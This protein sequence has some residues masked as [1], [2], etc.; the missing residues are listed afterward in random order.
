[1]PYIRKTADE[2]WLLCNYGHGEGWEHECTELKAKDARERLKEYRENAP[3]YRY[4]VVHK[5]VKIAQK[6]G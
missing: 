1:M 5:R 6:E 4:R 3:E 2:Y